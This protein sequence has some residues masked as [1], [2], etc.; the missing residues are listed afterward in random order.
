MPDS[1]NIVV[2][3]NHPLIDRIVKEEESAVSE[4]I[5]P[6][7]SKISA[8]NGKRSE[9]EKAKAG[10]KEEEIAQADKDELAEV[11][12]KIEELNSKRDEILKEFGR[13]T[14]LISQLIDLALLSNNMLKGESLTKF[15]KRSIELI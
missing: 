3:S 13:N 15:V 7:K 1:Y 9:L 5:S 10:K 8:L 12:K 2:N 4:K 11:S 6:I 14:K